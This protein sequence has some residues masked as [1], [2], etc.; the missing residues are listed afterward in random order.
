MLDIQSFKTLSLC[1]ASDPYE[2]LS[3]VHRRYKPEVYLYRTDGT[4]FGKRTVEGGDAGFQAFLRLEKPERDRVLRENDEFKLAISLPAV[5][6]EVATIILAVKEDPLH[7]TA[8][9]PWYAHARYR[10]LDEETYQSVEYS[11]LDEVLEKAQKVSDA[12]ADDGTPDTRL[13][14]CGRLFKDDKTA[15]WTYEAYKLGLSGKTVDLEKKMAG[16]SDLAKREEMPV[17]EIEKWEEEHAQQIAT[18]AKGKGR[19]KREEPKAGKSRSKIDD[20]K[21]SKTQKEEDKDEDKDADVDT[22]ESRLEGILN[23]PIGPIKLD[24]EAT[25]A[26]IEAKILQA[27]AEKHK[28]IHGL[29]I[30]GLEIYLHDRLLKNPKQILRYAHLL[31]HFILR[32]KVP[33]I[34]PPAALA[35]PEKEEGQEAK[36]EQNKAE[37]EE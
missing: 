31:P 16:L 24:C 10:L 37:A 18:A 21:K 35:P 12:P 30:H 7:K 14:L 25:V 4:L 36:E 20:D 19:A 2:C 6:P 13:V 27:F 8:K 33:E 29:C 5:P 1:V 3:D 22:I 17:I 28:D 34:I 11:K 26:D 15:K 32:P 23:F 9:E